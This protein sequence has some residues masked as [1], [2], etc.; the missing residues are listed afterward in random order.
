MR[1]EQV[2]RGGR[3]VETE[4]AIEQR[5]AEIRKRSNELRF[6]MAKCNG[7]GTG[8]G[9]GNGNGTCNWRHRHRRHRH[10]TFVL[11]L[12]A[13]EGEGGREHCT[14]RRQTNVA[15]HDK[16]KLISFY[17]FIYPSTDSVLQH[18]LILTGYRNYSAAS[19]LSAPSRNAVT[20]WLLCAIAC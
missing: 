20:P 4:H 15:A 3:E 9:T 19:A 11:W 12:Q 1:I 2:E 18:Y 14:K 13:R 10:F 16:S 5:A 17:L 7:N 8:S 6:F